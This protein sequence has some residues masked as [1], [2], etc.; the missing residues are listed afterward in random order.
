[1]RTVSTN[2]WVYQLC[3]RKCE[4][5]QVDGVVSLGVCI[6][7]HSLKFGHRT[8]ILG[9]MDLARGPHVEYLLRPLPVLSV[10]PAGSIMRVHK[11]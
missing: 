8:L 1:M 5:T 4:C 6:L 9:D 10:Q 11:V 3:D 7:I 2:S